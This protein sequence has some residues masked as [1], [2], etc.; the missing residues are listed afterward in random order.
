MAA[1]TK[2]TGVIMI[3]TP[4]KTSTK[5]VTYLCN[6]WK[7]CKKQKTK[8][9]M[10]KQINYCLIR[11]RWWWSND[12]DNNKSDGNAKG[13]NGQKLYT[14]LWGQPW[15]RCWWSEHH[16]NEDNNTTKDNHVKCGLWHDAG[17]SQ[18][19][20]TSPLLACHFAW[21]WANLGR[22]KFNVADQTASAFNWIFANSSWS[23]R[24]N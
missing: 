2:N 9:Q 19:L 24:I 1:I 4:V 18:W 3:M 6:S 8:R 16:Q 21:V 12:V 7:Q 11:W 13:N 5:T 10:R 20:G 15:Q 14:W 17:W 22:F 23:W